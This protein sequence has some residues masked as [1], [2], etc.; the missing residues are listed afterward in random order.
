[1]ACGW[2]HGRQ[3]LF[4]VANLWRLTDGPYRVIKSN[5]WNSLGPQATDSGD[6]MPP[7]RAKELRPFEE[8]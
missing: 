2:V 3:T 8:A 6:E 4:A 1:M 5:S 7:Y